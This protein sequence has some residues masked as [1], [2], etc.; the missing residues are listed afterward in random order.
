MNDTDFLPYTIADYERLKKIYGVDSNGIT[1]V[2]TASNGNCGGRC[3]IKVQIKDGRLLNLTGDD[4]P[5]SPGSLQI[6]P[7]LRGQHYLHTFLSKDRLLY[8]MKRIGT[9]GEGKFKRISWDEALD[10]LASENNRIKQTYGPASRYCN[11][12]TGYEQCCATPLSMIKRLL[13]LDGG[14]LDYYNNYSNSPS[15]TATTLTYGTPN[16]G[17]SP[18]TLLY[19]KLIILWGFNPA[20]TLCGGNYNYHLKKAKEN[21]AKIIVI[22][23]RFSDTA[24][25]FA[26]Q[27]IAPYPTTDNALSDAMAYTIYKEKLHDEHFLTAC[28]Q[29]FFPSTLP[30]DVPSD[31]SYLSYLTGE[32]DGIPKTPRWAAS[33]TGVPA[34]IIHSLAVEYASAKPAAILEGYG[35]A[36]HAYGE[37]FSR[38]LITLACMTGNIGVLGGSAA[39]VG[40]CPYPDSPLPCVPPKANNPV[41][42][43]IPCYRWTDAVDRGTSLTPFDG[44]KNGTSLPSDI[45]MIYNLAGNCLINQHGNAGY[46]SRLLQDETKA[47]FIVCSD[48]FM[49]ASAKF[50]DL[51]LPGATMFEENNI[52]SYYSRFNTYFKANKILNPPGECRFDY[53]WILSLAKRLGL[54]EEFGQNKTLEQ[55]LMEAAASIRSVKP[56]FP[57][58]EKFSKD[59]VYKCTPK[60]PVIAFQ[61]QIENPAENP[62]P[63][64][65]GKIEIFSSSLYAKERLRPFSIPHYKPAWEGPEDPLTADYPL[66]CIGWHSKARTHS[67]HDNNPMLRALSPQEMWMNKEDAL[68]RGIT[69]GQPVLVY[70]ARG[71]LQITV[72][73]TERIRTGVVAIPQGAWY[74]PSENHVDT[75]GCINTLTSLRP[76]PIAQANAQHTNLVEVSP[77]DPLKPDIQSGSGNISLKHQNGIYL[78]SDQCSGCKTCIAACQNKNHLAPGQALL[79]IIESQ[80]PI[81]ES[82]ANA[83]FSLSACRQCREPACMKACPNAAITK[84][85][86]NI[87]VI[88]QNLCIGCGKC[89]NACPENVIVF[90]HD[91]KAIKCTLCQDLLEKGREP[92][93]AGACPLRLIKVNFS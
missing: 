64:P 12:A 76:T 36:R 54:Y 51:L 62:F 77:L 50:A 33:I 63:T 38:G 20:E 21:G 17:N 6:R 19:S 29:G 4:Q 27:W 34:H 31:Y 89:S 1:T 92:A 68:S 35:A 86:H 84:S 47:E 93:C 67:V 46:T 69:S 65:S 49:T 58:Y 5:E 15:V 81:E 87:V 57:S 22:D 74:T 91:K 60:E 32:T 14:F 66:Q 25:A 73:V 59:G 41:K 79:N 85:A 56:G 3:V 55:W 9:R 26:S 40:I 39:G 11:Y 24:A 83:I 45:K 88:N 42:V 78:S 80:C 43:K 16:S 13:S 71:R 75:G 2:P 23:P 53:D 61:K 8:P 28:C 70:N 44:L 90:G 37:Q 7:C 10:W 72:K 82:R 18:D 48:I 30:E 52:S